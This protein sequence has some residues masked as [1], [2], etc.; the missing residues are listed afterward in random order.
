MQDTL[1]PQF[2]LHV[3]EQDGGLGGVGVGAGAGV[4]AG[5]GVGVEQKVALSEQQSLYFVHARHTSSLEPCRRSFQN[6]WIWS[7]V[8]VVMELVTVPVLVRS[9]HI[10]F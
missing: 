8:G 10:F 9:I 2:L 5:D 4:G 3:S 6:S 7:L 1:N